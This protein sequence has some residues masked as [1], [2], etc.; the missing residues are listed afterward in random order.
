M[1]LLGQANAAQAEA[2]QPAAG[3]STAI[4]AFKAEAAEYAVHLQS[5][6]GEKR[7]VVKEPVLRWSNPAR[8]CHSLAT[9]PKNRRSSV[10]WYMNCRDCLS[11]VHAC[12]FCRADERFLGKLVVSQLST[13]G[14]LETRVYA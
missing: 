4:E 10:Y 1:L 5:R 14:G 9:M 2:P 11:C 12:Q 13:W 3:S 8:A 7:A 6:A